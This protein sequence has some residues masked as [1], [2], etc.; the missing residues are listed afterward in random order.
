MVL[1]A[2]P[3]IHKVKCL[4]HTKLVPGDQNPEEKIYSELA[5][6]YVT[7]I[8]IP[9]LKNRNDTDPLKPYT[10]TDLLVNIRNFL[11]SKATCQA[12]IITEN[13]LFEEL[14]M[15]FTLKLMKGFS[16]KVFYKKLLQEEITQFL[17]PWAYDSSVDIQ[18]GGKVYK[19]VL[20][21]FIEERSYVDFITDVKLYHVIDQ[22]ESGDLEEVPGSTERSVLVSVPPTRHEI[23]VLPDEEE[24]ITEEECDSYESVNNLT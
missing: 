15:E 6:G 16:D 14:R 24:L 23:F 8:T 13:P 18:F 2:F 5:P 3:Q 19:S 20:I 17:T 11:K 10:S 7:V 9:N 12:R 1:E 4:S 22:V 21:D